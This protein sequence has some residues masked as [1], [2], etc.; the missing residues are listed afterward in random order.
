MILK[1]LFFKISEQLLK[2]VSYHVTR[3]VFVVNAFQSLGQNGKIKNT[4]LRLQN[5]CES[6]YQISSVLVKPIGIGLSL[7]AKWKPSGSEG[8]GT[9]MFVTV[10]I[11]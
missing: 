7:K 4:S 3:I 2:D 10:H 1:I 9:I 5:V 8:G 11:P 6:V